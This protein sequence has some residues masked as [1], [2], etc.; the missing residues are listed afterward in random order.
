MCLGYL[1]KATKWKSQMHPSHSQQAAPG[2][3]SHM[4]LIIMREHQKQLFSPKET[5]WRHYWTGESETRAV[6]QG[7]EEAAASSAWP[8]EL[9]GQK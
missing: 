7:R 2:L 6:W 8:T 1:S 4:V 5:F 9:L 3:C